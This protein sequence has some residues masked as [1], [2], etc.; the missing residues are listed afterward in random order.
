MGEIALKNLRPS[1]FK[2]LLTDKFINS[3]W[4]IFLLNFVHS[5]WIRNSY[6]I[7]PSMRLG[8]PEPYNHIYIYV[9]YIYIERESNHGEKNYIFRWKIFSTHAIPLG[10][11]LLSRNYILTSWKFKKNLKNQDLTNCTHGDKC[12][13]NMQAKRFSCARN[14]M[15]VNQSKHF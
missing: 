13:C 3:Y 15:H 1:K 8:F 9:I 14:Y 2:W 5:L 6:C 12:A 10:L 11:A 4:L 7:A